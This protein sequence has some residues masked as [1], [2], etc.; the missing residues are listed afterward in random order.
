[1]GSG[2][3]NQW[4]ARMHFVTEPVGSLNNWMPSLLSK[5]NCTVY[6]L[7]VH[8][9]DFSFEV[10]RLDGRYD[11]LPY[12]FLTFSSTPPDFPRPCA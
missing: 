4:M 8:A 2:A 3:I 12:V 11:W 9:N 6:Q 10:G 5:W 1:M 7:S